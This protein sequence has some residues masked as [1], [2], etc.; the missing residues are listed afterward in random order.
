MKTSKVRSQKRSRS[1]ACEEQ[2]YELEE[3]HAKEHEG[4]WGGKSEEEQEEEKMKSRRRVN[5][6]EEE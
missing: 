3:E 4:E 1:G 5:K 2:R 6:K